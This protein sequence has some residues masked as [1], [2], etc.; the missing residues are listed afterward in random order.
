ME[1]HKRRR[2][3]PM[4]VNDVTMRYAY[5]EFFQEKRA[6][7]L[8]PATLSTY[9]LHINNFLDH[10][11]LWEYSTREVDKTIYQQWIENLREDEDKKDVTVTSYARTVRAFLYWIQDKHYMDTYSLELPKYQKTI[12]VCYTDEELSRLLERP[13]TCREVEYQ[14]WVFIN[15]I[16]ATGMRLSSALAI[17]VADIS[18]EEQLVYVQQTKNKKAQVFFL[19]DEL[20]LILKRYIS[21]FNLG[22]E[23]WLFCSA[24]KKKLAKRTMQGYVSEY[25]RKRNVEK[26]SIHLMRHTFAKNY[27]IETKDIYTLSK[28]LGHSSIAVTEKYLTDLG[29]GLADA[30]AYNPQRRFGNRK[31]SQVR[32]SRNSIIKT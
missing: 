19:S 28:I 24:S 23:D 32:R 30:T 11:D 2:I 14:A 5:D 7:N 16:C 25:N 6:Q 1:Q 15:F 10:D 18:R 22:S 31:K 21:Q 26:T 8:A 27:Y 13:K 29:V 9:T 17:R 4:T 20:L 3:Q 12:K